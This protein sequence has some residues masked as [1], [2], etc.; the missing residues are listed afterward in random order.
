[1]RLNALAGA[2]IAG[3]E[4]LDERGRGRWWV[5]IDGEGYVVG[6]GSITDEEGQV[7]DRQVWPGWRLVRCEEEARLL[8]R[9]GERRS[10]SVSYVAPLGI[11]ETGFLPR[12]RGS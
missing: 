7:A 1:M 6:S 11:R 10:S 2:I 9:D 3:A 8:V 4:A 5:R 12:C